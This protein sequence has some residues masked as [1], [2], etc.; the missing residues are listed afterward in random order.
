MIA[1]TIGVGENFAPLAQLAAESCA[2]RTGLPV[3]ILGAEAME[4]Y[5]LQKPHH[6]KFKL[7]DEFPDAETILYFDSDIIFLRAFDPRPFENLEAFICVRDLW[8]TSWIISDA[9]RLG[10]APREYFNSG[11]F[12]AHRARHAAMLRLAGHL[13]GRISASFH[14]Q[15]HLNA[16]RAWLGLPA[17]FLPREY[18]Y[19][20]RDG[21]PHLEGAVIGHFLSLDAKPRET[22]RRFHQYWRPDPVTGT[23]ALRAAGER[24]VAGE[25]T[26]ERVGHDRRTI[27]LAPGGGFAKGAAACEKSWRLTEEE[28]RPVLW[29]G[30]GQ[31]PTCGLEEDGDGIW[32]GRWMR[33]EQMP[34][35]LIPLG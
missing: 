7:F 23:P 30:N 6:L 12:I 8:D 22:Q 5:G 1:V 31:M 33:W 13:Q 11:F 34:I 10:L 20:I 3:A 32:Q 18:N 14:D 2:T 21:H 28:G 25:F 17:H 35:R 9:R 26:Y 24:I 15:T 16:A 19:L 27:Q 29:L 4:K